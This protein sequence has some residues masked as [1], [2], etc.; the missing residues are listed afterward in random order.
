MTPHGE[1]ETCRGGAPKGGNLV[2]LSRGT[3]TLLRSSCCSRVT[4]AGS[5]EVHICAEALADAPSRKMES[6]LPRRGC[7][8]SSMTH[9]AASRVR[10][11]LTPSRNSG[12]R[13]SSPLH[14]LGKCISSCPLEP[15]PASTKAAGSIQLD[16]QRARGASLSRTE[17]YDSELGHGRGVAYQS[18][19]KDRP[20]P[21]PEH[22][23]GSERAAADTCTVAGNPERPVGCWV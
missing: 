8:V 1:V 16:T 4:Q 23:H 21:F 9:V 15:S 7:R 19:S 5:T 10:P 17:W 20:V 11:K 13:A 22:G 3:C 6:F 18:S 2:T 12:S 14:F